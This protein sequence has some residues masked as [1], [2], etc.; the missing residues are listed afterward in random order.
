[1]SGQPFFLVVAG[2]GLSI[3]GFGGLVTALHQDQGWSRTELWRLR[4]IVRMGLVCMFLAL[5]PFPVY[6]WLGDERLAMRV[7]SGLIAIVHAVESIETFR[8][9]KEWLSRGWLPRYIALDV[10]FIVLQLVNVALGSV[11]LLEIGLLRY[12]AH[13]ARLFIWV[14]GSFRPPI[15]GE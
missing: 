10:A 14:I 7:G 13:P 5:A 11:V 2:L 15:S 9:R 8:G 12:L 3:A 6:A 1:M 4:N